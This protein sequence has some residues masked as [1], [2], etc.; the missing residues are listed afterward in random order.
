MYQNNVERPSL[1]SATAIWRALTLRQKTRS[2]SAKTPGKDKQL[3]LN[4]FL[5]DKIDGRAFH[6]A[7][8]VRVGF[9]LLCRH[10]F[11][12]ALAAYSAALKGI[13]KRAGN[14]GAYHETITVAFLSLIA[15]HHAAGSHANF[16][17]FIEDNPQLLDKSIL[18]R[19]YAPERLLSDIARKTFVMPNG[20]RLCPESCDKPRNRGAGGR[21]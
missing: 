5:G 1:D 4:A 21:Q 9:E 11:P 15:E 19:W 8:H 16:E 2:P 17:A 6:H 7:D 10:T 13:A 12:D 3:L 14:P 20:D 18:E